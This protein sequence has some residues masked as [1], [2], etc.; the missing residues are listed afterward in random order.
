MQFQV[1]RIDKNGEEITK[2]IYYILQFTDSARFVASSVSNLVKNPSEGICKIK[3][4]FGYDD[5][6]WR[7]VKGTIF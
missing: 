4:K 1:T 2:N 6:I 7:K 3:C 5:K